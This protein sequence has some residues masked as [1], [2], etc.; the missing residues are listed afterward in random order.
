MGTFGDSNR[1]PQRGPNAAIV[2]RNASPE[3]QATPVHGG[4]GV[5]QLGG[6]SVGQLGSK[7]MWTWFIWLAVS[8]PR[9]AIFFQVP[10]L[11]V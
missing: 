2:H 1:S 3:S 8:L 7:E 10:R 9:S 5:A 11:I 4:T 6:G